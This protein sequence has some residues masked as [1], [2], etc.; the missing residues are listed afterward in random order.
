VWKGERELVRADVSVNE[1]EGIE[2]ACLG[3]LLRE[4]C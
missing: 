3:V 4:I 1:L 2:L